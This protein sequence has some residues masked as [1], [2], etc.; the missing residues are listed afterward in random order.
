MYL[1]LLR[2]SP[3]E[4]GLVWVV[5]V[6]SKI[7]VGVFSVGEGGLMGFETGLVISIDI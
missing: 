5:C 4:K 1:S 2:G 6:R 3:Q 7:L